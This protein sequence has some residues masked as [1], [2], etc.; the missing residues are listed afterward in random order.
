MYP[1]FRNFY[2]SDSSS[3]QSIDPAMGVVAG[4]NQLNAQS[5]SE[6]C[7]LHVLVCSGNM[8]IAYSDIY[9]ISMGISSVDIKPL[10]NFTGLA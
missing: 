6:F 8:K 3:A 1:L 7:H 9:L 5:A 10:M 4:R 2:H